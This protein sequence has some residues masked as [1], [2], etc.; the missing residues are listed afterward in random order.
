MCSRRSVR[1]VRIHGL[2]QGGRRGGLMRDD[3]NNR[4]LLVHELS[5]EQA[6][7]ERCAGVGCL[8]VR[9][10]LGAGCRVLVRGEAV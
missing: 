10:V 3:E 5:S 4:R 9:L 7:V 8:L 6:S 2:E 1:L